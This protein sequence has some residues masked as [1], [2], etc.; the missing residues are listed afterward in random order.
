[1]EVMPWR[2]ISRGEHG[3]MTSHPPISPPA[4]SPKAHPT[5]AP[6]RR[7][8]VL[9]VGLGALVLVATAAACQSSTPKPAVVSPAKLFQQGLKAQ[10]AGNA[11]LARSDYTKVL[12]QDPN[13]HA[14]ENKYAYFN[15]GV[16]D[17]S[18][19]TST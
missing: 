8:R 5:T 7:S 2:R 18:D 16:I 11:S 10:E 3:L 9:A 6:R 12:T 1:M 4:E 19:G 15:L 17:Q 13:N 14:G